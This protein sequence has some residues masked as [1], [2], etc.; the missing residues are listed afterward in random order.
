MNVRVDLTLT[1]NDNTQSATL[2][3]LSKIGLYAECAAPLPEGADCVAELSVEGM[4]EGGTHKLAGRVV[5]SESVGVGIEF[6]GLSFAARRFVDIL[7][8]AEIAKRLT[9]P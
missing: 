1:A 7:V 6:T 9:R 4:P 3:D 2:R 5:R 8:D